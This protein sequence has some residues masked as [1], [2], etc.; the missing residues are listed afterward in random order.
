MS[1]G[2]RFDGEPK[3]NVKKVVV[4]LLSLILI[5]LMVALMIN[6]LKKDK[7]TSKTKNITNSYQL[8][9]TNNK[10]G[11]INSK[12]EFVINPT[13]NEMLTIPDSTKAI[14]IYQTNVDYTNGTYKSKAINDKSEVLFSGYD[15]VE[16]IQNIDSTGSVFYDTNTLKVSKDGK[17]GLINFEGKELLKPEY[18][19]IE[20]LNKI[21]NCYVT[22][23]NNLKGLVDNAGNVIIDNTYADIKPL[24]DKYEN[25]FVVKNNSSQY[26][27]VNYTKQTVLECKYNEILPVTGSD[28][29]VVKNNDSLELVKKGDES[30]LKLT[31]YDDVVSIDGENIIV[32][33]G[34]N[35]GVIDTEGNTVLNAEYQDLSYLYNDKYIAKK[36]DKYG[37]IDITGSEVIPFKYTKITYMSEEGFIEAD[38]EDGTTDLLDTNLTVK[39]TGIVS[40]INTTYSF[41][42]VREN[43]EYKYYKYTLEEEDQKDAYPSNTIFLSKKDGKYGFVDKNGIVIVDYIYDDATEENKFGYAAVKKDGKW[44]AIDAQGNIVVEPSLDLTYNTVISFIG[45]YHLAPDLNAN[46]YTNVNE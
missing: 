19:S 24:T 42:K 40:E 43:G 46:Y 4:V 15:S 22:T 14:F 17:Y 32:K 6:F 25:G 33:K 1:R 5:I 29:Y 37:I 23:K 27:L 45:K 38:N 11:I 7:K 18:D 2:R 34:N 35:Y 13:Y 41:V 9:F 12:G 31:G 28:M 8:V 3:L 16:A 21:K 39:C 30:V 26:G 36:N 10:W 20:T 44:G